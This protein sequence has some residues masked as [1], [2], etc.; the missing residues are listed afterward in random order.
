[1]KT[2]QIQ[3]IYIRRLE[4]GKSWRAIV[5]DNLES[6]S[7]A[8][9]DQMQGK[10]VLREGH[11]QDRKNHCLFSTH[12]QFLENFRD[13]SVSFCYSLKSPAKDKN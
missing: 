13:A 1:M 10:A 11:V 7:G 8:I 2:K 6:R 3:M 4:Q 9:Y 5:A 12:M